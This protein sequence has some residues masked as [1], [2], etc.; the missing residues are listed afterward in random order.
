MAALRALLALSMLAAAA[1]VPPGAAQAPGIRNP[2][3]PT[4]VTLYMHLIDLNDFPINTQLPDDRWTASNAWGLATSTT[5]CL[6]DGT[7]GADASH[8]FHTFYGYSTPGYVEYAFESNDLPRVHPERGISYDAHLDPATPFTL[9]WYMTTQTVHLDS[10]GLPNPSEAPAPVP[11]VEV[12][13]TIRAGDSISIDDRG[14]NQGEVLVQG[15]T[16]P[17]T[18]F[19]SQA[20]PAAGATAPPA[21]VRALGQ[22][23]DGSWLYEF[24]VPMSIEKPVFSRAFG[25]NLR[26]DVAMD[27][28]ACTQGPDAALMPNLVRIASLPGHRPRMEF[29]VRNPVAINAL[30]PQF[31]GDDLVVH[32]AVNAVWGNYDVAEPSVYTPDVVEDDIKVTIKGPSQA[33]SLVRVDLVSDTHPHHKHQNDVTLVYAWPYKLDRAAPGVYRVHLEVSNDQHTAKAVADTQFEVGR[34]TALNCTVGGCVPEGPRGTGD[35]KGVPAPA[36]PLAALALAGAGVAAA[37]RRR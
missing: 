37:R 26:V 25:Y 32:A 29:A 10:A 5:T 6:P 2:D 14:Y 20:L 9:Y 28:P 17:A 4:P 33:A 36:A 22:Q 31:V 7:P 30:H 12:S 23:P 8:E 27:N 11:N 21:G 19:A 13:A 34:N 35:P 18:L 3:T 1:L 16:E 15:R 24:A